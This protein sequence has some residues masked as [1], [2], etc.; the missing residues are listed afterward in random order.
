MIHVEWNE[1]R[2]KPKG[3]FGNNNCIRNIARIFSKLNAHTQI[4]IHACMPAGIHTNI[5]LYVSVHMFVHSCYEFA[6]NVLENFMVL[7]L[8]YFD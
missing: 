6:E 1:S 2:G 4:N 7:F 3:H 8:N 5:R